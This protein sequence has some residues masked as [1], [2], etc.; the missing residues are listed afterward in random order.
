MDQA[1]PT[2]AALVQT[3]AAGDERGFDALV[4]RYAPMVFARCRRSLDG[5]DADDATQAVFL[6]L[7]RRR[8]QAAASPA[9]AAWLLVTADLVTRRAL[10]DRRRRQTAERSAPIPP[11]PQEPAM[12]DIKD[13]LDACLGELPA[14]ERSAVQLHCLAGHTLAEVAQH[15]GVSPSAVYKRIQRGVERLRVLLTRR[16]IT[17]PTAL[18]LALLASEARAAVPADLMARLSGSAPAAAGVGS[19]ATASATALR[20]SRLESSPVSRLALAAAAG[21][22]VLAAAVPFLAA[23]PAATPSPAQPAPSP[24]VAP[25]KKPATDDPTPPD[26]ISTDRFLVPQAGRLAAWI[27]AQPEAAA[28]PAEMQAT[29][30]SL[31]GMR[32]ISITGRSLRKPIEDISTDP[33]T[34]VMRDQPVIA[35]RLVVVDLDDRSL[36]P[37]VQRYVPRDSTSTDLPDGGV[38]LQA[39]DSDPDLVAPAP[40]TDADL[41]LQMSVTSGQT[42]EIAAAVDLRISGSRAGLSFRSFSNEQQALTAFGPLPAST[43]PQVIAQAPTTAVV[44]VAVAPGLVGRMAQMNAGLVGDGHRAGTELLALVAQST[45]TILAWVEP[46]APLPTITA[47]VPLDAGAVST[48]FTAHDGIARIDAQNASLSLGAVMVTMAYRDGALWLTTAPG[49]TISPAG[50]FAAH[51]DAATGMQAVARSTAPCVA[52]LRPGPCAALLRPYLS[53]LGSDAGSSAMTAVLE[54]E[55]GRQPSRGATAEL[56]FG[57]DG[58][59]IDATGS[60]AVLPIVILAT[61]AHETGVSVLDLIKAAN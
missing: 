55:L 19:T 39:G 6:V 36:V 60:L 38:R 12:D 49:G 11:M 1:E 27:L 23:E 51:A 9:I 7:A 3:W 13:H 41:S 30:A 34:K 32:S 8:D 47:R 58:L 54:R 56:S 52:V 24:L 40:A 4:R 17:V 43:D 35:R 25:E 22:I 37:F 42:I 16:G 2:D 48:Y 20:W 53:L 45:G 21:L 31:K 15:T 33:Q 18:I 57:Q 59:H 61:K 44:A 5:A 46:G 26:T 14:E 28:L 50:G 10:R 29:I